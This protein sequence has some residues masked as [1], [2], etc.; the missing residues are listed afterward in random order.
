MPDGY[1]EK[2]GDKYAVRD[3]VGQW[4]AGSERRWRGKASEAM[5]FD[6]EMKALEERNRHCLGDEADLLQVEI[7]AVL[8]VYARRWSLTELARHLEQH[9]KS[10]ISGP[11]GKEGVLL[12]LLPDTLR[13]VKSLA[14]Y[15]PHTHAH[16]EPTRTT[17]MKTHGLPEQFY[18]VTKPSPV[19]TME[20]IC[21]AC[22]FERL[23]LQVR[24]GLTEDEIVGI[25]ADETEA[26]Q[27]AGRLLGMHPVRPRTWFSSRSSSTSRRKPST[28]R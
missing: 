14:G 28:R 4:W 15:I 3:G 20:D 18:I 27:A 10:C 17:T 21:F 8:T 23:M 25:Y 24:G 9:R 12:E 19:S 22:T 26:R 13:K 7:V 16:D 1:V 11:P 5:L 2:F 6:T